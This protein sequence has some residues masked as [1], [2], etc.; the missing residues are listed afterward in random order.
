MKLES[1]R[2]VSKWLVLIGALNWGLI[3]LLNFNLVEQLLGLYPAIVKL[4][5]LLIGAA[6]LWGLYARL[7]MKK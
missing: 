1:L 2:T 6:G 7:T 3:G 5:Y 4:V